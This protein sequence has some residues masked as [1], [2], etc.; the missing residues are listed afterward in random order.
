MQVVPLFFPLQARH[1][2]LG[3]LASEW[4][5]ILGLVAIYA[6]AAR[7][8]LRQVLVLE[9]PATRALLGAALCGLSAWAVLGLLAQWIA[10]APRELIESLR[11]QIL[12]PG[13]RSLALTILLMAI[14]P[15]ICEEAL[16]RGP[17]LRGLATR[18]SPLAAAA[19]TGLLFGL[20][21]FDLWR[22]VPTG[23]LGVLLSLIA[24][25]AGS[26]VLSMLAHAVNNGC[27]VILAQLGLDQ[28]AE[29]LGT[30]AQAAFF[31]AAV[32]VMATGAWLV[33]TCPPPRG[34]SRAMKR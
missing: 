30:G 21:H 7:R 32:L 33:A 25:R 23:L 9:R 2:Q 5:G 34:A 27:L 4:I 26:I 15:A 6:R 8:T 16:F 3:L 20:F 29:S 10:P 19:L 12:P 18:V 24:W 31:A 11:R 22:L 28:R 17:I 13:G 14:T 1:P